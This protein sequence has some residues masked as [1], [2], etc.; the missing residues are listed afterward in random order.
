MSKYKCPCCGYYTLPKAGAYDICPVCYWE[1]DPIQ[2]DDPLFEG[3][4]NDLCLEQCRKNYRIY[5]AC[6]E[7]F[8][9]SVRTPLPEEVL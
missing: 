3:G 4:A 2:E 8:R 5:G 9:D 7:R 6:E 1:D